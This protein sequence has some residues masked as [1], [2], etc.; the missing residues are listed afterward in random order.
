METQTS[1][2]QHRRH[3]GWRALLALLAVLVLAAV[4]PATASALGGGSSAG[5]LAVALSGGSGAIDERTGLLGFQVPIGTVAGIGAAETQ[6]Q[7]SYSQHDTSNLDGLGVGWSWGFPRVEAQSRLVMGD[8]RTF[9]LDPASVS[10]LADHRPDD[11]RF[12]T[13]DTL[14]PAGSDTCPAERACASVL[15]TV[16]GAADHFDVD[17]RLAARTDRFGNTARFDHDAAGRLIW[18]RGGFE[19]GRAGAEISYQGSTDVVVRF[20]E[21]SD[22]VVPEAHLVLSEGRLRE[23]VDPAGARTE[24]WWTSIPVGGTTTWLPS[25]WLTSS[26]ARVDVT[27]RTYEP[28]VVGGD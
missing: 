25:G 1:D 21:R 13:L 2:S 6:L 15:R 18:I 5:S 9:A 19:D 24:I 8:G 26:G 3:G 16:D 20:A 14:A 28:G 4:L 12:E 11:V 23:V 27:Y 17:G 7:V 22:G 10:G